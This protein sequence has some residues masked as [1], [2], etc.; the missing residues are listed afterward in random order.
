MFFDP[1]KRKSWQSRKPQRLIS[2]VRCAFLLSFFNRRAGCA[3]YAGKM[4][5]MFVTKWFITV[6]CGSL[7]QN[8]ELGIAHVLRSEEKEKLAKQKAA[9]ADIFCQLF[10]RYLSIFNRQEGCAIYAGK[11]VQHMFVTKWFIKLC[12]LFQNL[13]LGIAHVRRSE[14][15][16]K[17]AKQKAAEADIF[18]Q[19]FVRFDHFL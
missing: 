6:N 18:C 17:L 13:D 2:S 4:Q 1:R 8:L 16:E 10:F 12:D 11:I 19:M 7:F 14:E 5:H 9:E 15:K 3:I